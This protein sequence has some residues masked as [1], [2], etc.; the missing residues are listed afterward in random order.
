MSPYSGPRSSVCMATYNGERYVVE[1]V[2][3]IL[4]ELLPDDELVVVDDA[5][6][7]STLAML[8]AIGDERIRIIRSS[9]NSGYVRAF[10]TAIASAR[11]E[12]IF[13]AD[14]DDVWIPGRMALMSAALEHAAVVVGNCEH[15]GGALTPF[16]RLRLR[17]SDSRHHARNILGIL[18]GYRLHWGAAM[19]FRAEFR[20]LALPFPT[21]MTESH[22]QWIALAGNVARSIRYLDEDVVRHRLHQRNVTPRT[23][24]R[25]AMILRARWQ[26]VAELLIALRRDR[27]LRRRGR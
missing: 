3:S 27:A 14:Q 15:F 25:P 16:L 26:F 23:I 11:G 1:Q 20:R 13:L 10:E 2:R 21:G 4:D 24:R 18:V 22:D 6:T 5:S 9:R 12:R 19:A 7:D 17:S 8:D